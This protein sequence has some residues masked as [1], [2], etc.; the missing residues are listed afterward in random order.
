MASSIKGIVFVVILTLLMSTAGPAQ[1]FIP[2]H[3][4]GGERLTREFIDEEL[5]YPQEA[6]SKKTEGIVAF[7]FIVQEQGLVRNLSIAEPVDPLLRE[8]ATRIFRLILWQPAEYRGKA[9]ESTVHFEIPF[10]IRHYR[11]ACRNRGYEQPE[12]ST[13]LK[14]S[15]G[16]VYP[17]KSTDVQPVPVFKSGDMNLYRFMSENFSYPEEALKRNITGVV[18]LLF[19]VEPTGRISNIQVVEHLGAGCTEEAIRLARLL[20]WSPG[21]IDNKAVRVSLSMPITFGLSSDGGYKVTPAAGQ[22]TFQ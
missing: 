12:L 11:K 7:D 6:L 5:V 8:E 15:S 21:M 9:V 18:K 3:P 20:R 17:Y 13:L 19:I 16:I 2:A 1:E 4:R 22:T 10:N 14:D